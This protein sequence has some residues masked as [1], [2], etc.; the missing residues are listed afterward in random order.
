MNNDLRNIMP[1]SRVRVFDWRL[2]EDD[3]STPLTF[4]VRPATVVRRYGTHP[5]WTTT[6]YGLKHLYPGSYDIW[7][8]PDC[9]D[10]IFDHR[11]EQVSYGH[12]TSGVHTE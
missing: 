2:F 6:Q 12:F 11:P 7:K 5:H 1:G 8:Y 10:V 9:V 4:T 3:V